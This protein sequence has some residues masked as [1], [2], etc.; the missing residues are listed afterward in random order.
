MKAQQID[1]LTLHK[2]PSDGSITCARCWDESDH[3][4]IEANISIRKGRPVYVRERF[5]DCGY[6][7]DTFCVKHA[8]EVA[9]EDATP[10]D[11]P[12]E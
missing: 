11:Q 3:E 7:Y 10:A 6:E 5:T 9:E 4:D 12:T 8:R 2:L 1:G